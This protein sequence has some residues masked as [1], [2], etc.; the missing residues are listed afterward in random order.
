MPSNKDRLL[1]KLHNGIEL[2]PADY[3]W[4]FSTRHGLEL[5]KRLVSENISY[6]RLGSQYDE[7]G[8]IIIRY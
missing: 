4:V 7:D 2:S 8:N 3:E 1:S 5:V 6:G